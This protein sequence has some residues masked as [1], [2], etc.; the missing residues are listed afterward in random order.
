MTCVVGLVHGKKVIMGADSASVGGY[1]HRTRIDSKVFR[2][3]PYLIGYTT[4]FRMGQLLRYKLEYPCTRIYTEKE[5]EVE[6]DLRFMSTDF[7][8][9]VRKCLKEGG[10]ARKENEVEEGGYFLV[11]YQGRLYEIQNDYQV[12][13]YSDPYGAVGCG[14]NFALGALA[15]SPPEL[16]PVEQVRFALKIAEKFSAGVRGPFNILTTE[17]Y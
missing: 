10:F 1:D 14:A 2:R 13:T 12:A 8:D 4:S 15:A 17:D 6:A 9:A 16:S 3:G 7:I 5:S 11:G